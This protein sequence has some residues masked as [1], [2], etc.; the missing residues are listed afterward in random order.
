MG[1]WHALLTCCG[2]GLVTQYLQRARHRWDAEQ[3]A[4]AE[5]GDEHIAQQGSDEVDREGSSL[6]LQ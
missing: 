3:C 1:F 2:V 4:Q 6:Q 5:P